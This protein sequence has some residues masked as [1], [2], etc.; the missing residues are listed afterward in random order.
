VNKK[1][2]IILAAV[3]GV[4]LAGIVVMIFALGAAEKGPTGNTATE[5][6]YP[7]GETPLPEGS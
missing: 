5:P 2:F 3:L 1:N 4:L 6:P 7:V